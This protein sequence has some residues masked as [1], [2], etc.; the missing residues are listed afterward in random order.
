MKKGIYL[1]LA[2]AFL[3]QTQFSYACEDAYGEQPEGQENRMM[4]S[5]GAEFAQ[6]VQGLH[7]FFDARQQEMRHEASDLRYSFEVPRNALLREINFLEFEKESILP[8]YGLLC[9]TIK[10]RKIDSFFREFSQ[11]GEIFGFYDLL[12]SLVLTGIV[13]SKKAEKRKISLDNAIRGHETSIGNLDYYDLFHSDAPTCQLRTKFIVMTDIFKGMKKQIPPRFS[14][15]GEL[16]QVQGNLSDLLAKSADAQANLENK[17]KEMI[18]ACTQSDWT[19]IPLLTSDIAE[20]TKN[21]QE[22]KVQQKYL[23]EKAALLEVEIKSFMAQNHGTEEDPCLQFN[24]SQLKECAQFLL[25]NARNF[26]TLKLKKNVFT[27]Q[28][29]QT[30]CDMLDFL[31]TNFPA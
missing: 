18:Q 17:G 6:K 3:A 29:E 12:D 9:A 22:V 25:T 28:D 16:K 20:L 13:M 19:K 10:A 11:N 1:F 4:A 23:E 14:K 8:S 15:E 27:P 31:K 24:L 2:S 21:V 26:N 5:Q 30:V 7:Q